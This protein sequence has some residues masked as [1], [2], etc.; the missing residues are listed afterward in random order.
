MKKS[1]DLERRIEHI[2]ARF[3]D[4]PAWME[5]R[6]KGCGERWIQKVGFDPDQCPNCHLFVHR[7]PHHGE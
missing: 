3:G 7:K 5:C 6:T 2:E 4:L 1:E